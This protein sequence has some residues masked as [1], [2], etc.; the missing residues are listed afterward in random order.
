MKIHAFMFMR[1]VGR[2]FS[3]HVRIMLFLQNELVSL[4]CY[5]K[6]TADGVAYKQQKFISHH[7]GS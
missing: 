3:F 5:S 2:P 6:I 4:G 1:C 7:F